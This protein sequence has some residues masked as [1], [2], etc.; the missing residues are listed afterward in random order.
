[1]VGL[2]V[3]ARVRDQFQSAPHARPAHTRLCLVCL[4]SHV[5]ARARSGRPLTAKARFADTFSAFNPHGSLAREKAGICA[6]TFV[7]S[8]GD[9]HPTDAG[10]RVIAAAVLMA[11]GYTHRS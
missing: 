4:D 3:A 5:S 10:Y 2:H 9:G 6:L 1:M 8:E 7:C 11:S